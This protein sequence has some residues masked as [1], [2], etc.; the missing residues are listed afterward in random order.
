MQCFAKSVTAVPSTVRVCDAD[1]FPPGKPLPLA[2][3]RFASWAA[4][5]FAAPF[6]AWSAPAVVAP[7][8]AAA[9]APAKA[10]GGKVVARRPCSSSV[11]PQCPPADARDP[12]KC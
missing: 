6:S 4:P 12:L 5:S 10:W 7:P 9:A 3:N 11:R 1:D 2:T 8:A